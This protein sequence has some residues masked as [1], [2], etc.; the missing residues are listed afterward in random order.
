MEAGASVAA[1]SLVPC[2]ELCLAANTYAGNPAVAI[3]KN[4]LGARREKRSWP[5]WFLHGILLPTLQRVISLQPL[6]LLPTFSF[7]MKQSSYS[8]CS[9]LGFFWWRF[10]LTS[11]AGYVLALLLCITIYWAGVTCLR[12]TSKDWPETTLTENT[13]GSH[14]WKMVME[15]LFL[16][17]LW[18]SLLLQ[19]P[20]FSTFLRLLGARVGARVCFDDDLGFHEPWLLEIG[21]DSQFGV[22]RLSPHSLELDGSIILQRLVIGRNVTLLEEASVFGGTQVPDR[23]LL[24]SFCRPL[25][26]QQLEA[27]EYNSTPAR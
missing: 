3:G 17:R 9:D 7:W 20:W 4:S 24:G 6:V 19:T 14:L 27:R 25:K 11:A 18:T 13:L 23:C 1:S 26:G 21:E 5:Q 15:A 16:S 2:G 12:L 8:F 22:A 10:C